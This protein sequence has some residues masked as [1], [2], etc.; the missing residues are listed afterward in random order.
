M[1]CYSSESKFQVVVFMDMVKR[2]KN[3]GFFFLAPG[4]LLLGSEIRN[5]VKLHVTLNMYRYLALSGSYLDLDL[6]LAL[7]LLLFSHFHLVMA[8]PRVYH[9]SGALAVSSVF[10]QAFVM[11]MSGSVKGN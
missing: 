7:A 6:A 4:S 3:I 8:Q 2:F 5:I 11:S 1:L 9:L 10:C